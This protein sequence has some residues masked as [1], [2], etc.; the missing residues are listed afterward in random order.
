MEKKAP[1]AGVL[2]FSVE[3]IDGGWRVSVDAYFHP[4]GVWGLAYWYAVLPFHA[5]IFRGMTRTIRRRAEID[6]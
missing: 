3:N 6:A 5:Y 1:G 2:E 4:A